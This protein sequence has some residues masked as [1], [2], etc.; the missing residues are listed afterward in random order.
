MTSLQIAD[1]TKQVLCLRVA[2]RPEHADEALGR[3]IGI[4]PKLF[5]ADRRL[6]VIAQDRFAG[7]MSP[8]SITSIPSRSSASAKA[9]AVA[10]W[11]R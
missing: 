3:R 9:R 8:S 4:G 5:E 2:A 6:D 7:S 11:L 10:T 1:D